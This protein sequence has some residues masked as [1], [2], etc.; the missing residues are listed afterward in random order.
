MLYATG[1]TIY[2]TILSLNVSNDPITGATFDVEVFQDGFVSSGITVTMTI[3]D[4]S[5]GIFTSSWSAS[6][7]GNYQVYYKNQITN[8]IYM[9]DIFQVTAQGNAP[10]NIFVGL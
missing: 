9:S 4:E 7:I 3:A 5:R 6:T 10:T 2:D 8:I 1:Q